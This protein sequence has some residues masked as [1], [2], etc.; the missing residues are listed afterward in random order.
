MACVATAALMLGAGAS[1]L[2]GSGGSTTARAAI[3][4]LIATPEASFVWYPTFPHPSEQVLL[5]SLSTDADS[6]LVAFSWAVTPNGELVPDGP[7]LR[8]TFS[9][10]A[11]QIVRLRVTDGNHISDVAAETIHMSTPPI[12][13]LAPFPI[14][15]IDDVVAGSGIRIKTLTVQAGVGTRATITC[16]G[17]SCPTRRESR[18]LSGKK[19]IARLGF[20]R[21][22]RFLS[23]GVVL[24]V[25]V[26]KA[27]KIGSYT[28]L[29]VRRHRLPQRVDTCLSASGVTPIACP[30]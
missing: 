7:V 17:R 8:T 12:T 29:K 6:P 25:R 24:E 16:R 11:P 10:Y 26:T 14:V 9:T 23:A 19:G 22:E 21:F 13:V 3:Y 4:N 1:L 5:A 2:V 20:R 28:R 18:V 27:G 30:V 15:R